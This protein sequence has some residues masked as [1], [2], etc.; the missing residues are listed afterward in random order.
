[1]KNIKYLLAL[2]VLMLTISAQA[3]S[4]FETNFNF[5]MLTSSGVSYYFN[6]SLAKQQDVI[7]TSEI[8]NAGWVCQ[9]DA[10]SLSD[11]GKSVSGIF[12]C[13]NSKISSTITGL[14]SCETDKKNSDKSSFSV[15]IAH[16]WVVFTATCYTYKK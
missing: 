6:N 16:S 2:A 7:L 5:E 8:V 4:G 10:I 15:V 12:S 9:R 14:V 3:D 1:M 13:T 11:D